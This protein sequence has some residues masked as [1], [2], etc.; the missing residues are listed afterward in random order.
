MKAYAKN[1]GDT[2]A[3]T[4]LVETKDRLGKSRALWL[5]P[6]SLPA[7]TLGHQP[8]Q[9]V[10]FVRWQKTQGLNTDAPPWSLDSTYLA[11]QMP[12]TGKNLQSP[13]PWLWHGTSPHIARN[14]LASCSPSCTEKEILLWP[15]SQRGQCFKG[16][17]CSVP[18]H[19][20]WEGRAQAHPCLPSFCVVL[21]AQS[22]LTLCDFSVLG[23]LQA[24]ILEWVAISFSRDLPSWLGDQTQVFCITGG[25]FILWAARKLPTGKLLP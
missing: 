25:F 23:I 6:H 11:F 16:S 1:L 3:A 10:L 7:P 24:R 15:A 13:S 22:Y 5:S 14:R 2:N 8:L 20:V 17:T 12:Q 18:A 9:F 4:V 19:L 21:V